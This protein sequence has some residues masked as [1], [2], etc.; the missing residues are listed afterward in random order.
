MTIFTHWLR[1]FSSAKEL[2]FAYGSNMNKPQMNFRCKSSSPVAIA[3]LPN[4][5]FLIN[6]RGV[7]TLVPKNGKAAYGV[8]WAISRD[9]E[10]SLDYYEGVREKIYYKCVV[11]ILIE[12]KKV[13]SLIYIAEDQSPGVPRKGYL[14]TV[15]EGAKSFNA[16]QE[17]LAELKSWAN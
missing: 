13:S 5:K 16:H 11:E 4:W 2:Y 17:W 14:E 9:N 1:D 8:V 10:K 12:K 7:A 15:I 3:K 6:S